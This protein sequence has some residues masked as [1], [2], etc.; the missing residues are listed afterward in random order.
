MAL[1]PVQLI[2]DF[3]EG[4]PNWWLKFYAQGT[5]TPLAMAI[6]STGS[7]TVDKAEISLGPTPPLGLIKTAGNVTFIPYLDQAYD[8]YLFPTEAEADANDTTN[9]IQLADDVDPFLVGENQIST[10]I[11]TSDRVNYQAGNNF[12]SGVDRT[13]ENKNAELVSVKDFGAV[14]DGVTDDTASIQAAINHVNS[15]GGNRLH[16]T[17]GKYVLSAELTSTGNIRLTGDG[18]RISIWEWSSAST[19]QGLTVT[20]VVADGFSEDFS[21]ENMGFFTLK[22]GSGTA[23]TIISPTTGL[24]R[25]TVRANITS[26]LV[27]GS[28]HPSIDGW[29]Y[30]LIFDGCPKVLVDKYNFIGMVDGAAPDYISEGGIL[31]YNASGADPH[32]TELIVESSFISLTKVA[33]QADDMEGLFVDTCNIVGNNIGVRASGLLEFPHV[34][35]SGSHINS[36]L[37]GIRIDKMFEAIISDNLIYTQQGTAVGIGVNIA[38][39]AQFFSI[40]G[41]TFENLK[42]DVASNCIII[43]EG[44]KGL[45]D[46]N[47]FRRADSVDTFEAG[48]GVWL[49]V[50]SSLVT[51]TDT[52]KYDSTTD[53]IFDEGTSNIAATAVLSATV[54]ESTSNNGVITKW[55]SNVVTLDASGDGT[56]TFDVEFPGGFLMALVNNGN[57]AIAAEADF[58]VRQAACTSTTLAFAVRADPGAIPVQVNWMAIGF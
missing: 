32:P 54:G 19:T 22:S 4:Y 17:G 14:G 42:V 31:Y 16:T 28:T 1:A 7:P 8:A 21:I 37:E 53:I 26:L 57:T 18:Q 9:A 45:I 55:G 46:A 25:V 51:V 35:I 15:T 27:Q 5:T 13:Q 29:I 52:N 41:N 34:Y 48:V 23:I 49:T 33:I 30:G 3:M 24:D 39:G 20:L 6:N 56:V 40:L 43:D 50:N 12:T 10:A 2:S 47:T 36:D 44:S 38:D 58:S 11:I